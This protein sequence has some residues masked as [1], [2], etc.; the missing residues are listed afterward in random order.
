ASGGDPGTDAATPDA[1]AADAAADVAIDNAPP[2]PD[3]MPDAGCAIAEGV[4]PAIDGV[5]DLADYPAAQRLTPGAMLGAD[6][7]AIAWDA[8]QLYVTVGSTAFESDYEPVHI[9]LQA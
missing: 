7:V 3:A 1:Q 6:G 4:S 5:G 2:E 9:Y 8:A